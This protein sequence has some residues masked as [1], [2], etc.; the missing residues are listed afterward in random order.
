M[1]ILNDIGAFLLGVPAKILTFIMGAIHALLSDQQLVD[2]A[3]QAVTNAENLAVAGIEKQA[4]AKNEVI[5]QLAAAGLPYVE[6]K[7]NLAIE[8]A[9]AN[10][11][12]A[13]APVAAPV[14]EAPNATSTAPA[15]TAAAGSQA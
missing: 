12:A 2:L 9:V 3:M 15:D 14:V 6:S 10:L 11:K 8:L 5:G 13:T 7:V 4:A 1:S